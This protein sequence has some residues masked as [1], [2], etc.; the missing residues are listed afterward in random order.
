VKARDHLDA[1][2][3]EIQR[4]EERARALL[5]DEQALRQ[6]EFTVPNRKVAAM[7]RASLDLSVALS[8][9]RQH[10]KTR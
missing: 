9:M 4:F 2:L 8:A 1:V 10:G 6:F 3:V 5:K 7:R